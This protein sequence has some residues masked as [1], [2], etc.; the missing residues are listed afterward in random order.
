M[1]KKTKNTGFKTTD[2]G[3]IRKEIKGIIFLLIT[4]L[5]GVSLFSYHPSDPLFLIKTNNPETVNNLFGPAGS[6]ISGYLFILIGFSSFWLVL[7]FFIMSVLSFLEKPLL[8]PIIN[9]IAIIIN[10]NPI[11]VF[12]LENIL[13]SQLSILYYYNKKLI[14]SYLNSIGLSLFIHH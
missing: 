2:Y 1:V 7:I 12:L 9:I 4:I 10:I 3:H 13:I 6:H 14:R 5:L 8:P 11:N